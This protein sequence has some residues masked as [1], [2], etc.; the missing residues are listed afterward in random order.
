MVKQVVKL[1]ATNFVQDGNNLHC[2]AHLIQLCI[3]DVLDGKQAKPPPSTNSAIS[4]DC[5]K[6]ST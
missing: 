5:S 4:Q 2:A 6:K 3:A 1:A